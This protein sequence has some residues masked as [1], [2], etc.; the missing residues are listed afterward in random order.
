[1]DWNHHK[2]V[3]W[4][5]SE[6]RGANAA[7][8]AA[9]FDELTAREAT[10]RLSPAQADALYEHALATQADPSRPWNPAM[11]DLL[12]GAQGAGRLS[13][14][15]WDRYLRQAVRLDVKAGPAVRHRERLAVAIDLAP[16]RTGRYRPLA[17][18]LELVEVRFD[19][20]AVGRSKAPGVLLNLSPGQGGRTA[21]EVAP[22]PYAVGAVPDG[23]RTLH[24]GV[25][26]QLMYATTPPPGGGSLPGTP[27]YAGP[28]PLL[29]D[30]VEPATPVKLLAEAAPIDPAHDATLRPAV[31]RVMVVSAL[32]CRPSEPGSSWQ[33][34]VQVWVEAERPPVPLLMGVIARTGAGEYRLGQFRC[35]AGRR[36]SVVIGGKPPGVHA[37]QIDV[38]L[39]PEAQ[40]AVT[41]PDFGGYRGGDIVF[42]NLPLRTPPLNLW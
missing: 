7:D 1:V 37:D 29:L 31:E 27:G 22:D 12:D 14:G 33:P 40:T 26:F 5:M 25:R 10:A 38:M 41:D 13:P 28:L 17:L 18:Y 6:A 36:R 16:A 19:G 21:F 32:G 30:D 39:R 35:D 24:A 2:P 9:A 4:L 23:P 3:W 11:G 20:T 15:R 34:T 8:A 42:R